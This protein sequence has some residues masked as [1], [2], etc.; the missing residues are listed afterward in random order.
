MNRNPSLPVALSPN[1]KSGR[2]RVGAEAFTLIELLVVIAIIGILA[3]LLLPA[4][5]QAK[6]RTRDAQCLNNLRQQGIAYKL[7]MDDYGSRFPRARSFWPETNFVRGSVGFMS[8][9][10]TMG[11]A[12][13]APGYFTSFFAQA[14]NRPLVNY[15]GNPKVFQCPVDAG[16]LAYPQDAEVYPLPAA[17]PSMWETIGCSYVYNSSV[18]APVDQSRS[19]PLPVST[20]LPTRGFLPNRPESFVDEPSR[21]ILVTEPPARPMG[22]AV[23]PPPPLVI[24]YWAQWH[25]SYGRTDFLDPTIAPRLFVSPTLFVDGHAAVHEFS[26]QVMRDPFYPFEA[27]KDWVWYQPA[28]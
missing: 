16:H 7:Y 12:D 4:L 11:G 25:R 3:S 13:P 17:K 9:Q 5:S 10:S 23:T 8:T 6:R 15:Q 22:R 1:D 26:E 18:S 27:T 20:L 2:G 21:Y 14:T 24:F 19:P 28:N